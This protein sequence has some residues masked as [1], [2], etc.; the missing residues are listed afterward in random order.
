MKKK[1]SRWLALLMA[2][3]MIITSAIYTSGIATVSDS[4]LKAAEEQLAAEGNLETA[5]GST[6]A[7]PVNNTPKQ[8]TPAEP[9]AVQEK[10]IEVKTPQT[11]PADTGGQ[12][13][14]IA[15]NQPAQAPQTPTQPTAEQEK[16]APQEV[17]YLVILQKPNMAGGKIQSWTTGEKADSTNGRTDEVTEN[18]AYY[19]EVTAFEKYEVEK[20]TQNGNVIKP[21]S[22]DGKVYN[23]KI[24]VTGNTDLEVNY[25][26]VD[27]TTNKNE[28]GDSEKNSSK[29]ENSK[30]NLEVT[31]LKAE[32]NGKYQKL[33]RAAAV[34][35]P[36]TEGK[37][38]EVQYS[39]NQ[40]KWDFEPP[41][42]KD[43]TNGPMTVYVRAYEKGSTNL[44]EATATTTI[45]ITPKALKVKADDKFYKYAVGRKLPEPSG[46][47][48]GFAGS[49]KKEGIVIGTPVF[50][51]EEGVTE[52]ST[53]GEYGIITDISNLTLKGSNYKLES[54]DG[55]IKITSGAGSLEL[56]ASGYNDYY[57][58]KEHSLE[59]IQVRSIPSLN[60]E[61][62][63]D[64]ILAIKDKEKALETFYGTTLQFRQVADE[65]GKDAI[66]GWSDE[67]PT[68]T[69]EGTYYV[70][71]KAENHGYGD[72][73][74]KVEK[75]EIKKRPV[76]ITMNS[77]SKIY[78][79]KDPDFKG[80][81]LETGVGNG[82][83]LSE[84]GI[85]V[86]FVRTNP[87]END[88]KT[89][90]GV[91]T[92]QV[93]WGTNPEV[94]GNYDFSVYNADFTIKA[95]NA[96]D[97]KPEVVRVTYDGKPHAAKATAL[98]NEKEDKDATLQ[99]SED[100]INW[101]D[102]VE[103]TAAGEYLVH[104]KV[105]K[106]NYVEKK[107]DTEAS[108][109]KVII[110]KA[111]GAANLKIGAAEYTAAY[112]G[113]EH[114]LDSFDI[115]GKNGT[116]ASWNA[117]DKT[118]SITDSATTVKY[119]SGE[120]G[121]WSDDMPAFK[122][123]GEYEVT[124]QVTN[125][126]YDTVVEKTVKVVIKKREVKITVTGTTKEYG[127]DDPEFTGTVREPGFASGDQ[128]GIHYERT[129][130]EV[131]DAGSYEK[132]LDAVITW[133][134][135]VKAENYEVTIEKG[136]FTILE[137]GILGFMPGTV[138]ETYS[139]KPY[140]AAAETSVPGAKIEYSLLDSEGN[141]SGW[142]EKVE[143]TD[144]GE[145]YV[146][147][148]VSAK[149]YKTVESDPKKLETMAKIVIEPAEIQVIP[150]KGQTIAFENIKDLELKYDYTTEVEEE[151]PGF[152]GALALDEAVEKIGTYKIVKG[153][154]ELA[155]KEDFKK[156]NYN[157]TCTPGELEV[158]GTLKL[159]V[160]NYTG[161][162]DGK[163][164]T[165]NITKRESSDG[166][167]VG[168]QYL[169]GEGGW[170]D[171]G[172]NLEKLVTFKD[173]PDA[174]DNH[175]YTFRVRP[176]VKGYPVDENG[177]E[178]KVTI[179]P[180]VVNV[181]AEALSVPFTDP[182]KDNKLNNENLKY[183]AGMTNGTG[184]IPHFTGNLEKEA[185]DRVGTYKITQGT[186]DLATKGEF[187]ASNYILDFTEDNVK[188]TGKLQLKLT[189]YDMKYDAKQHTIETAA[190]AD[191]DREE[192]LIEYS[193]DGKKWSKDEISRKD[194]SNTEI[195]VRVKAKANDNYE[196][197]TAKANI[198]I[199]KAPL[200]IKAKDADVKYGSE[201][202]ELTGE[203]VSGL[204]GNDEI[205]DALTNKNGLDDGEYS[206]QAK[207]GSEAKDY[208][209]IAEKGALT[210]DNYEL[211]LKPGTLTIA[212]GDEVTV[213]ASG[214]TVTY[215]G[216]EHTLES[217]ESTGGNYTQ[218]KYSKDNGATWMNEI[219]EFTE[220]G[221]HE[222]IVQAIND[223]YVKSHA[224]V[225]VSVV[226][227]PRNIEI[228]VSDATKTYGTQDPAFTGIIKGE[229]VK[230][231]DLG[232]VVYKRDEADN[233]KEE[234][235]DS[236]SLTA[237]YA[238][239]KNY[240][241]TVVPGKLEITPIGKLDVAVTDTEAVYDGESKGVMA[242]ATQ[243]SSLM[244][245]TDGVNWSDIAPAYT[246]AGTYEV[247]VKALQD[248]YTESDITAGKLTILSRE[249]QITA[250]S[251]TKAYDG[252]ELISTSAYL[253]SGTL[254]NDEKITSVTVKGSQT[255]VGS[256]PN[257]ASNVVIMRGTENV[258]DNYKTEYVEGTLTVNEAEQGAVIPEITPTP[259]PPTTPTA[260]LTPTTPAG[261]A[262]AATAAAL[263]NTPAAAP[264]DTEELVQEEGT[265]LGYDLT[266][267]AT[268][269][270]PLANTDL[271]NHECCVFHFILMLAMLSVTIL[272]AGS[273][274]KR[275]KRLFELRREYELE[276]NRRSLDRQ[277]D[278]SKRIA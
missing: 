213:K 229:L 54:E 88:A 173:A 273:M 257:I 31:P 179:N 64:T 168:V 266:E 248:G 177:T 260:P 208:E 255:E 59:W 222:V 276:L 250:A 15:D 60:D 92:A 34:Y 39:I 127:K 236:I 6:E 81:Y 105:T 74:T 225:K 166:T 62:Q 272:Y 107:S 71:I 23:Y 207:A 32:Y 218:I 63:E 181:K 277:E 261:P 195:H 66:T 112:D 29:A 37:N 83:F 267:I 53:P 101:E 194:V 253:T 249:I 91:I 116:I 219:P 156:S 268:P 2:V 89:Y 227:E 56:N 22:V 12:S 175:T 191:D 51:Y 73:I 252:T 134:E 199:S 196:P 20:V 40:E 25:R 162:Y 49:D 19:M 50:R 114:T 18:T 1:L 98:L 5:E 11:T 171:A 113:K 140:Q 209:I 224:E 271:E 163:T 33:P 94:K 131:E 155:D 180:A 245:S 103:Y 106:P 129:N 132:V 58:T 241:V 198:K 190:S 95:S 192:L 93:D 43:V 188:I 28:T 258:T 226:I 164:H 254:A 100:G 237:G 115:T 96:L 274:K 120:A 147:V 75:V 61:I 27:E 79:E 151:T 161:K 251:A 150:K 238:D 21:T 55:K 9:V 76:V 178:V 104:V 133:G 211:I 52:E 123:A 70:E 152:T 244:Y 186:L 160:E 265:D 86:K 111:D 165:V 141:L 65:G 200:T 235:G 78:G 47:I 217:V 68:F 246:E 264:V 30:I 121:A 72:P 220:A 275:Q 204:Q 183:T 184:E 4:A 221:T 122:D 108:M 242:S 118:T 187:I 13:A 102:K 35:V 240:D 216:K 189:D 193:V 126:N 206:T 42:Q 119:K 130:K 41:S 48:T 210:S 125:P 228:H 159:E 14:P 269:E 137:S 45:E 36:E 201:I 135:G 145:Y 203:Y 143:K 182:D 148:R 202:P 124:I 174:A 128:V 234:I 205:A 185:G 77:A 231:D 144:A 149:N 167:P 110:E 90:K 10:P 158:T 259:V 233:S 99:Y 16:E 230:A 232:T 3:T 69:N 117:K 263:T 170:K 97:F 223:N 46:K 82:R 26:E 7:A 109:A 270:V 38:T 262:T 85:T 278:G 24:S 146:G 80:T 243:G 169:Y 212:K 215:D 239:N 142:S 157:L 17:K 84:D 138:K 67:L 136:N 176:Y 57:D 247:Y 44:N 214:K 172:E 154:L 153:T 256:S 8:Q 197:V 139:G 87:D